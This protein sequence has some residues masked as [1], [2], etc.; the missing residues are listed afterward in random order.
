MIEL[1]IPLKHER[2]KVA[3]ACEHPWA[4]E[5]GFATYWHDQCGKDLTLLN[6]FLTEMSRGENL[7][8]GFVPCTFL[9]AFNDNSELVGRVSIRHELNDFLSHEGGHIGYAVLPSFRRRGY[10]TEM[11]RL[12][13][14]YSRDR[15]KLERVLITCDDDNEGSWRVIEKNGGILES[16]AQRSTNNTLFRRY[17]VTL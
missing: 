11:L 15:L 5:S 4:V 12:A 9:F 2:D 16:R 6:T 7:P 8:D 14:I 1:R 10:A 17:W 3:Q 13:L